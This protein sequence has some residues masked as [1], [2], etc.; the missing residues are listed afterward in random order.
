MK[1]RDWV[2]LLF[3]VT[4]GIFIGWLYAVELLS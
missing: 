2:W 3:G 4:L 1:P